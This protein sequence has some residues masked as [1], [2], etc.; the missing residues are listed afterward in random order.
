MR[1]YSV[2][3]PKFAKYGRVIEGYDFSEVIRVLK[4]HTIPENVE[5]VASDPELEAL[6][7]FREFQNRFY[8]EMPAELGYCMGHNDKLNGLEYHRGSEVNVAATD[9]IVMVGCQQDLEPGFRYDSGKVEA[10]YV[11]EGY[12][13]EYYATTL[14]LC[15]CHT[16]PA[17]YAHATFLPGGTNTPLEAGFT[18]ET[19]EDR[20][21]RMKNKWMIAH[22]EGGQD[23]G[24][25]QTIYGK[26][27]TTA[28]LEW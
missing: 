4:K 6:P 8:G 14:H 17:G 28:D 7:V 21:L 27:W 20:I 10:F 24:I 5:Y 1:V 22:P 15:A 12:A 16:D 19:E 3:D 9:Y 23:P 25:L 11:P 18:A 2:L 13:V 26:N